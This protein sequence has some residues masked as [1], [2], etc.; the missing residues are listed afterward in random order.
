VSKEYESMVGI[1]K[2]YELRREETMR[3]ARYWF[4]TFN[5]NSLQDFV[6]AFT[7]EHNAYYRMVRPIGIWRH[8]S[9]IAAR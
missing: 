8:L 3:Q 1:M 2:L 9:L 6:D 5:P 4:V 7:G